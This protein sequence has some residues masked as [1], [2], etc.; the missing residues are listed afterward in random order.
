MSNAKEFV[1]QNFAKGEVRI[2]KKWLLYRP[3][4]N[5]HK[6]GGGFA[7]ILKLFKH[8]LSFPNVDI[9]WETNAE[10]LLTQDDGTIRGVKVRK[11]DG[12]F[13]KVLGEQVML[14]CGGFE[15][16]REMWVSSGLVRQNMNL[17]N[18]V[19]WADTLDL[20]PSSLGW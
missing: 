1:G 10:E 5:Y 17:K 3:I 6:Q 19:G 12:R 7:I 9:M 8:I 14:S 15:G 13:A 2:L 11:N 16:N 20:E 18:M 4:S